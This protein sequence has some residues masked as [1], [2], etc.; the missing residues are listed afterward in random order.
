M[1]PQ[2]PQ[3]QFRTT[4]ANVQLFYRSSAWNKPPGC[5]QIY[6]MLIGGG[7]LNSAGSG[8]GSGAVTT[9]WGA[10]QNVPDSLVLSVS[11]GNAVNTTVNYR[12]SNGLNALLTANAGSGNTGASAMTANQFTA[13]GF[14]QSVGGQNGNNTSISPS[15]TTFLG[16]GNGGASLTA[17]YGYSVTEN[18][19]FFQLQPVI[20]GAGGASSSATGYPGGIGCGGSKNSGVGGSG[21]IIIAAW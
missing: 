11:T 2:Q 15:A 7:G 18:A 21:L 16:G 13:S 1:F 6:M 20:F 9:W 8:G 12:G 5:S 19:G 3:Q 10:A 14:F 4:N 17:N